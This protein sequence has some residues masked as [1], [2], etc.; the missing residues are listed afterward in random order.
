MKTVTLTTVN[1]N[2]SKLIREIE[3]GETFVITRRG[4]PIAKLTPHKLEKEDDPDW[5][6]AYERMMVHLNEG[7]SLGGL[8]VNRENFYDC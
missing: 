1:R 6:C 2:F 8:R 3:N 7:A 5:V 4:R